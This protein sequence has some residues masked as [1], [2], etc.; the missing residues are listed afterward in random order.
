MIR[1]RTKKKLLHFTFELII[2]FSV[3]PGFDIHSFIFFSHNNGLY[4]LYLILK[5]KQ[6]RAK[7]K[8]ETK[9]LLSH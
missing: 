8:L 1:K 9:L 3:R 7:L 2:S 4:T 5:A 6:I